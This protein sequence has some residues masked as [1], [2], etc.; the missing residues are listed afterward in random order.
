MQPK[1]NALRS[2]VCGPV[3]RRNQLYAAVHVRLNA[4]I[5]GGFR[6]ASAWGKVGRH[7][8]EA[9][10]S[11]KEP[12]GDFAFCVPQVPH[13]PAQRGALHRQQVQHGAQHR[14]Q[15]NVTRIIRSGLSARAG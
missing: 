1:A 13:R 9:L 5:C 14:Q 3:Q 15:G 7:E 2:S 10:F 6:A 12:P 11:L 8:A 4:R